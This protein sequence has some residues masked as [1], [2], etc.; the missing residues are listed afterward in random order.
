MEEPIKD[1]LDVSN[2]LAEREKQQQ[3]QN[4]KKVD[5]DTETKSEEETEQ[6]PH[7]TELVILNPS[8]VI[9]D[10]VLESP[11]SGSTNRGLAKPHDTVQKSST[12]KTDANRN[13]VK[14]ENVPTPP[15]SESSSNTNTKSDNAKSTETSDITDKTVVVDE[16]AKVNVVESKREETGGEKKPEEIQE[17]TET[18]VKKDEEVDDDKTKNNNEETNATVTVQS[19]ACSA[20]EK[21]QQQQ[22][23][24]VATSESCSNSTSNVQSCSES[25]SADG[26]NKSVLKQAS[27]CT[28]SNKQDDE[29][30]GD[31]N[32][33]EEEVSVSFLDRVIKHALNN[34]LPIGNFDSTKP[35]DMVNRRPGG[36]PNFNVNAAGPTTVSCDNDKEQVGVT[37]DLTKEGVNNDSSSE[38]SS[39]NNSKGTVSVQFLASSSQNLSLPPKQQETMSENNQNAVVDSNN[40]S[41]FCDAPTTADTSKS[42]KDSV[43]SSSQHS[44]VQQPVVTSSVSMNVVTSSNVVQSTSQMMMGG[45]NEEQPPS[46]SRDSSKTE[47]TRQEIIDKKYKTKEDLKNARMNAS[48][49]ESSQHE[50]TLDLSLSSSHS[51]QPPS[52]KSASLYVSN[53][54]FS[55][56]IFTAPEISSSPTGLNPLHVRPPDFNRAAIQTKELQI[57][58][59]IFKLKGGNESNLY[60]GGNNKQNYSRSNVPMTQ[61]QLAELSKT[62]NYIPDL[63]L[64]SSQTAAPIPVIHVGPT[65]S[66]SHPS[67][68]KNV[69]E[70]EPLPHVIHKGSKY[71]EPG[72]PSGIRIEPPKIEPPKSGEPKIHYPP[73]KPKH[74]ME[75]PQTSQQQY[76][77]EHEMQ[78]DIALR[79]LRVMEN[80]DAS[81]HHVNKSNKGPYPDQ[82][83]YLMQKYP[84]HPE[85]VMNKA[86]YMYKMEEPKF[87]LLEHQQKEHEFS[88]KEKERQLRQEGTI[89][90]VKPS[91]DGKHIPQGSHPVPNSYHLQSQQQVQHPSGS[92]AMISRPP[93]PAK[94]TKENVDRHLRETKHLYPPGHPSLTALSKDMPLHMMKPSYQKPEP[95]HLPEQHKPGSGYYQPYHDNTVK[96]G[97]YQKLPGHMYPPSVVQKSGSS[98]IAYYP[99]PSVSPHGPI[100]RPSSIPPPMGSM[101]PPVNWPNQ[102]MAPSPH[103]TNVSPINNMMPNAP[104]PVFIHPSS[105]H[106]PS[107]TQFSRPPV[108]QSPTHS[109]KSVS[110]QLAPHPNQYRQV[111]YSPVHMSTV[112]QKS[113]VDDKYRDRRV[114]ASS[115]TMPPRHMVVY[116]TGQGTR[117]Y[118]YGELSKSP[119]HNMRPEQYPPMKYGQQTQSQQQHPDVSL[120]HASSSQESMNRNSREYEMHKYGQYG[121]E[122]VDFR[123]S[124]NDLTRSGFVNEPPMHKQRDDYRSHSLDRAAFDRQKEYEYRRARMPSTSPTESYKIQLDISAAIKH[125]T[126]RNEPPSR[127]HDA[128]HSGSSSRATME[129][130]SNPSPSHYQAS[131]LIR[132]SPNPSNSRMDP[133]SSHI[134]TEAY[135]PPTKEM[136]AEPPPTVITTPNHVVQARPS[137]VAPVLKRESPLDLSVKTVK[138]KADSTGSEQMYRRVDDRY[139]LPK[140]E[141][142][143]N[144]MQ[145][146]PGGAR[147]GVERNHPEQFEP[148]MHQPQQQQQQHPM[149]SSS[150]V[151]SK[152][153]QM[154]S[155]RNATPSYDTIQG[156]HKNLSHIPMHHSSSNQRGMPELPNAKYYDQNRHCGP[157]VSIKAPDD[158][159][160][161]IEV[162]E[163]YR[164]DMPSNS[165]KQMQRQESMHHS[166][167]TPYPMNDRPGTSKPIPG[168]NQARGSV[169]NNPND[170]QRL[171]DRK[172]V[173]SI[174]YKKQPPPSAI[175]NAEITFRYVHDKHAARPIS[176]RKRPSDYNEGL[177]VPSKQ[178]RYDLPPREMSSHS[179]SHVNQMSGGHP[180]NYPPGYVDQKLMYAREPASVEIHAHKM[181]YERY[182]PESHTLR[183]MNQYSKQLPGDESQHQ[184]QQQQ[185]HHASHPMYPDPRQPESKSHATVVKTIP[186]DSFR[187]D[188]KD[189][190]RAGFPPPQQN[191]TLK[192]PPGTFFPRPPPLNDSNVSNDLGVIH[193]KQTAVT[194][195]PSAPSPS[196]VIQQMPD[197]FDVRN[198]YNATADALVTEKREAAAE[199]LPSAVIVESKSTASQHST[200]QLP[201]GMNANKGAD[202]TTINKLRTSIEQKEIERQRMMMRKQNSSEISEDDSNKADIASILAARIRTKGELKGFTPTPVVIES[203]ARKADSPIIELPKDPI[204]PPADIEGTSAFDVMDWGNACNDFVDQLQTGK[205]RGRRKRNVKQDELGEGLK[206]V[207]PY[208]STSAVPADNLSTVPAEVLKSVQEPG[209]FSNSSDEDKPL[210]LLRQQSTPECKDEDSVDPRK[211][212]ETCSSAMKSGSMG[213]RSSQSIRKKQRLVLEQK[214]AARIGTGSSSDTEPEDKPSVRT[215]KRKLRTR[216]SLGMKESDKSNEKSD[217]KVEKQSD[218]DSSSE[219]DEKIVKRISQLDGSSDSDN[220]KS[221]KKFRKTQLKSKSP[222]DVKQKRLSRHEKHSEQ[223]EHSEVERRKSLSRAKS[224]RR[225]K[226]KNSDSEGGKDETMTRS[227]RKLEMEKKISNSKVLRNDK[228]VQ[229]VTVKKPKNVQEVASK[230]NTKNNQ[231]MGNSNKKKD[232]SKQ[233]HEHLKRKHL[234][235]DCEQNKSKTGKRMTRNLSKVE[236]SA[237]SSEEDE[238]S[239]DAKSDR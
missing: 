96:G 113:G 76:K 78:N 176:P 120:R 166:R 87:N 43:G 69:L 173:E 49:L 97:S 33:E 132:P 205:K 41:K 116:E 88:L 235:S 94:L 143:P 117:K 56:K 10:K 199:N 110:P 29:K 75:S 109:N 11:E 232:E 153:P 16:C 163:P 158:R 200:E 98:E 239:I 238:Q 63:R 25:S 128:Y 145:H 213:E 148:Q 91:N 210:K 106:S 136:R 224:S 162:G 18:K 66:Q 1:P 70:E 189:E 12:T 105:K 188:P 208:T 206:K 54:D 228:I 100:P 217:Q 171:E 187:H 190:P 61:E 112:Q 46:H 197:R 135:V 138:T 73:Y 40:Q 174:L 221:A 104:S 179:P 48:R 186:K 45:Q 86:P 22:P 142:L 147:P 3:Q 53:P 42:R 207:D 194:W 7:S 85:D 52:K 67:Q 144:F 209:N 74:V 152:Y 14:I 150:N 216:S 62:H 107:P 38:N 215:R 237:S 127:H 17:S 15:I 77:R 2:E 203:S 204:E 223:S 198:Q 234:E 164:H 229:N 115:P 80:K 111:S 195:H 79:H 6:R 90:T 168:Q 92:N 233:Q 183:P 220:E 55:K 28:S 155:H 185:R 151:A 95:H 71:P 83:K 125:E 121:P 82:Q 211:G 119:Q 47:F 130:Q 23:E 225:N 172:Y 157:D 37:S 182:P 21:K 84:T 57:P 214:I 169:I 177:Q 123:R 36:L 27:S 192:Y 102:R 32:N 167:H 146:Q 219:A 201:G 13:E 230:T 19:D 26:G 196:R 39:S 191:Q 154:P 129:V 141:F 68:Q 227:K 31:N 236:S 20:A 30:S 159:T 140:V 139:V 175:A 178:I 222:M 8:D 93:E 161:H 231:Q 118:D 184:Q 193:Q 51:S 99:H 44:S 50:Q 35:F 4:E 181:I 212:S 133:S 202:I 103:A 226:S 89:I 170:P 24:E 165:H 131:I 122:R 149:P 101:N 134:K 5:P 9:I 180:S 59:P 156:T 72:L 81:S 124:E 108:A 137:V 218:D 65:A 64:K 58:N 60:S 34:T 114:V 160:I 126:N